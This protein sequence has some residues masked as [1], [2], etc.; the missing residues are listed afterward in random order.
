MKILEHLFF[1]LLFFQTTTYSVLFW[2][3]DFR[4]NIEKFLLL[5]LFLSIFYLCSV[6]ILQKLELSK[7]FFTLALLLGIAFRFL[8]LFTTPTLSDDVYRY[9]WDGKVFVSGTNPYEF[10]PNSQNLEHLRDTK[11]FP[12]I[13]HNEIPTVYPPVLQFIFAI[14]GLFGSSLFGMKVLILLFE[15]GLGFLVFQTILLL[16]EKKEF[17]FYYFLNPLAILEFSG[18]AHS[19]VVGVFFLFLAFYFFL[20]NS[21]NFASL[22]FVC[23]AGLTKFIPFVFLLFLKKT[24]TPKGILLC[25]AVIFLAYLPFLEAREKL[26]EGFLI[27]S[28]HWSFNESVFGIVQ[29]CFEFFGFPTDKE[30]FLFNKFRLENPARELAKLIVSGLWLS[31]VL[32]FFTRYSLQKTGKVWLGK[33]FF[34]VW[35]TYF[36]LTATLQPWYLIW[37]LP[38]LPIFRYFSFLLLSCLVFVSYYVLK[39]FVILGIWKENLFVS[40]IEFVPFYLVLFWELWEKRLNF[41]LKFK[42]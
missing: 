19:D 26:F 18:Q 20:K 8:F 33:A 27:Y 42:E 39:D 38:F 4:L 16:R 25:F 28:K 2:L 7:R 21:E 35:A 12:K 11:I 13:N 17:F 9:V 32:Y 31:C 3:S 36:L 23:L 10:P 1:I 15:F 34:W 40:L 22:I 14:N 41:S 5:A 29:K 30:I 6:L 37:I 24:R